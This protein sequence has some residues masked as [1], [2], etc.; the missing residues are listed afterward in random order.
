MTNKEKFLQLVTEEDNKTFAEVKDRIKNRAMLKESQQ[1]CLKVLLKLDEIGWTQKQL[2]EA[3]DVT[4]QQVSKIVSGKENLTIQ[5][6]VKLQTILDIP[7]LASYYEN[8]LTKINELI[9]AFEKR[10]HKIEIQTSTPSFTYQAT[11]VIWSGDSNF[12][13]QNYLALLV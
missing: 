11:K 4:P 7:I 3:M 8:K 13:N 9:V 5:T 10:L 1:I 12:V 6:Q 2:A